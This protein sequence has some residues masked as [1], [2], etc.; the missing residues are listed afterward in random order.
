MTI[1]TYTEHGEISF[2]DGTGDAFVYKMSSEKWDFMWKTFGK[3]P[4][5]DN[6]NYH[7]FSTLDAALKAFEYYETNPPKPN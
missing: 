1:Y 7:A 2:S 4:C 3:K 5:Y 6:W